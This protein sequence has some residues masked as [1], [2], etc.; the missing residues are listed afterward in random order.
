MRMVMA[1]ATHLKWEVAPTAQRATSVLQ[2]R[3]MM[4]LVRM[5]KRDMIVPGLVWMTQTAMVYVMSSRC[6][7]VR[8]LRL[9]TTMD[10]QQK[11]MALVT[12]VH[13]GVTAAVSLQDRRIR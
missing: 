11:K 6:P 13:V 1:F 4:A 10:Q 12:S 3:M 8:M 5:Q 9:V 2:R 7:V